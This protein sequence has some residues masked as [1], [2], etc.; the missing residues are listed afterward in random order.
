LFNTIIVYKPLLTRLK[1]SFEANHSSM[2]EQFD[3]EN[4]NPLEKPS[5]DVVYDISAI[6]RL[7]NDHPFPDAEDRSM[8][9]DDGQEKTKE[10]VLNRISWDEF[11]RFVDEPKKKRKAK[12]AIGTSPMTSSKKA[13]PKRRNR[14]GVTKISAKKMAAAKL[15][16]ESATDDRWNQRYLELKGFVG[17]QGHCNVPPTMAALSEWMIRQRYLYQ[18]GQLA[19]DQFLKLD[20]LG[21]VWKLP[22]GIAERDD[23]TWNRRYQELSAF[24]AKHGHCSVPRYRSSTSTSRLGNWC[25]FQRYRFKE[26][27][28][29]QERILKLQQLGFFDGGTNNA[30]GVPAV[31]AL[32]PSKSTTTSSFDLNNI[33]REEEK[34][35]EKENWK[36]ASAQEG[37]RENEADGGDRRVSWEKVWDQRYEELKAFVAE[38]GHCTVPT[39]M[40]GKRSPLSTW[41]YYQRVRHATNKLPRDRVLKLER[42]GFFG[43][44]K[45]GEM[46]TDS[47]SEMS[48]N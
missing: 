41:V 5:E 26:N 3:A 16:A 1:S 11:L 42:L 37:L 10:E 44:A 27:K 28:M 29:P 39:F 33:Q 22:K 23:I 8:V 18:K 19:E 6:S 45:T 21:F 35:D 4:P 30:G 31:A 7:N 47:D 12:K 14:L 34:T 46:D 9:V 2:E 25:A 36:Q 43:R 32:D 24:V 17:N 15:K 48:T 20:A 13:S 40:G 38:Y